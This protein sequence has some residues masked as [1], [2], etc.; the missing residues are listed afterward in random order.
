MTL[1]G[2]RIEYVPYVSLVAVLLVFAL[3]VWSVWY[4]NRGMNPPRR[5]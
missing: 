2:I 1:Q 4:S 5:K 3:V